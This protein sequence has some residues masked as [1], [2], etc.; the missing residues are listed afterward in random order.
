MIEMDIEKIF[1]SFKDESATVI[2][3]FSQ[4]P[5]VWIGMFKKIIIN[6]ISFKET[7]IKTIKKNNPELEED[8]IRIAGNIILYSRAW[9]YIKNVDL[10]MESHID[11]LLSLYNEDLMMA[12]IKSKKHYERYEEYEKCAF[13]KSIIDRINLHQEE[14][15]FPKEET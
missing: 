5:V 9:E 3:D 4:H 6:H 7:I 8:E 12:L 14:F 2:V 11:A 15:G 13:I 10:N 1:A